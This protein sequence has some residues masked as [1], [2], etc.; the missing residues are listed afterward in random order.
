MN[1]IMCL[2]KKSGST[3]LMLKDKDKVIERDENGY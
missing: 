3:L 1:S 2:G